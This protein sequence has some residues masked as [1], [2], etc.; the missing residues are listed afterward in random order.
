[1]EVRQAV[2]AKVLMHVPTWI[3]A[4]RDR[5]SEGRFVFAVVAV[6]LSSEVWRFKCTTTAYDSSALFS[7]SSA[8]V[9]YLTNL[10]NE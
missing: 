9:S 4:A 5:P 1:M 3:P 7:L 10:H 6:L 2:N 8:R